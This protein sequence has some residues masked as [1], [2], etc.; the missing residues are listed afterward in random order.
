M[1]R[2][3]R[4]PEVGSGESRR[5][6]HGGATPKERLLLQAGIDE[7]PPDSAGRKRALAALGL[8]VGTGTLATSAKAAVGL[9]KGVALAQAKWLLFGAISAAVA[10]GTVQLATKPDP[11]PSLAKSG[12]SGRKAT[13][14][15]EGT[16]PVES[17]E[18]Q[19][20]PTSS[21]LVPGAAPPPVNNV[22]RAPA[23]A[24]TSPS[25]LVA[26]V[27][28]LDVARAALRAGRAR[29]SVALLDKFKRNFPRSGLAPE[30][31]VVR[32]SALLALGQRA[33]ATELA[34]AYC[35][36]GG[37]EAYGYRLMALVGLS[38]ETC[39]GSGRRP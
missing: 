39:E 27:A 8:A 13:T 15:V 24:V 18:P 3:P 35:Q 37:R 38:E 21:M 30:A 33:R 5:L 26:Q 29:E 12:S 10:V 36:S 7:A 9:P 6:V 22:P 17:A 23:D 32:V 20:R 1:A 11:A 14:A 34:R 2:S 31:T 25:E 4:E 16:R 28:A 19:T